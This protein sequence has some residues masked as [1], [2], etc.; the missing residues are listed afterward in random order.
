MWIVVPLGRLVLRFHLLLPVVVGA[1][2]MVPGDLWLRYLLLLSTLLLHELAHALTALG[3]GHGR[4]VVSLWPLFG[5][6]DVETFRDRRAALVALSA[7][8]LNLVCAGVFFHLGGRPTLALGSAPLLDLIQTAHL[9]MGLFNLLPIPRVDGGRA[10][11]AL[12][13]RV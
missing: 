11:V 2:C 7:P 6:A 3:L 13:N 1:I 5:R 8:L 4:A 9:L 10:L 12:R